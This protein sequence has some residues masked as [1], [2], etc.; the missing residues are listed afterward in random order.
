[1]QMVKKTTAAVPKTY[2]IRR[3]KKEG[4]ER[5]EREKESR[6]RLCFS[7]T[8]FATFIF[9]FSIPLVYV[10]GGSLESIEGQLS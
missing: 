9:F 7:V 1:M 8:L 5:V 3:G 4:P 2:K 6:L 10:G